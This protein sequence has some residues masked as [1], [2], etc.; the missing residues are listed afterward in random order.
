M[1]GRKSHTLH[2]SLFSSNSESLLTLRQGSGDQHWT[3]MQLYTY[4]EAICQLFQVHEV[5][6]S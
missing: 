4:I 2:V 6:R 1:V 5:F 3:Y